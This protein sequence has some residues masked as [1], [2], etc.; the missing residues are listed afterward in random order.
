MKWCEYT[1]CGAPEKARISFSKRPSITITGCTQVRRPT[2]PSASRPERSR[3]PGVLMAPPLTT[4][5]FGLTTT[6]T[7]VGWFFAGSSTSARTRVTL[8]A[9]PLDRCGP[10]CWRRGS[11]PCS[12]ASG[13]T[14]TGIDCLASIGQPMPQ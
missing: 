9:A 10:T 3:S 12:T 5:T 4:V 1:L 13:S 7:P 8:P 6:L 11:R 14:V 2:R